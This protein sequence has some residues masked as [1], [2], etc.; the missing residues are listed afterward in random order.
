MEQVIKRLRRKEV[1]EIMGWST[2]TLRDKR[3]AKEFIEPTYEGKIPYWLSTDV[4]KYI[5]HFFDNGNT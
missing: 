1:A 5:K 2:S 4:E 3:Y